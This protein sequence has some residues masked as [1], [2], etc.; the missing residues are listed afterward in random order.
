MIV[1]LIRTALTLSLPNLCVCC[2]SEE[3]VH[4]E[5]ASVRTDTLIVN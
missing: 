4:Y 3:D 1:S 5:H 2:V